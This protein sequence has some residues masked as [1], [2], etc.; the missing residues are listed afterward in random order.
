[1][2]IF[3]GALYHH[4]QVDK[5]T[6]DK[7]FEL[8]ESGKTEG[9]KLQCGGSRHGNKGFFV[10]STVFSDVQDHMRIAQ[11]EVLNAII[12]YLCLPM[13]KRQ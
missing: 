7:I 2:A 9:A 4:T 6:F 11:E 3:N 13:R 8:I 12:Y 1:M 10:E 5:D